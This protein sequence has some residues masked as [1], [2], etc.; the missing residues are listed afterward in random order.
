MMGGMS[1]SH[2]PA[3][4]AALG[5]G[6]ARGLAHVGALKVLEAHGLMPQAVAGT[7]YGA[8]IAALYA[9]GTPAAA[10]ETLVRQQNTL[11]LW[12]QALDLGWLQGS[13][14]HGRRL[15]RWLDRKFFLGA[16][17]SDTELPLAIA[18]TDL[19][20]GRV[21][22]L[23]E[24][25]IARAVVASCALPGLFAPVR[26]GGR[27]LIDG[28]LVEAVPF[29]AL[30][31]LGAYRAI[32]VHA[33]IDADS[34][35][36]VAALRLFATSRAGRA[37]ERVAGSLS[38]RGRFGALMRGMAQLLASYLRPQV[39]PDGALLVTVDPPIAWWDFHRSPEA[40]AAGE[41]AMERALARLER[42][43]VAQ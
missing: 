25:S 33:G 27:V 38:P 15:E 8:V 43:T 36:L 14:I 17:F 11:E 28:G 41:E 10:L 42:T 20:N 35:R 39:V 2:R 4:G 30:K 31:E 26:E 40:I 32:G 34:S 19:E 37:W 9:L 12:A 24:G 7:S 29:G 21:V 1:G 22:V 6:T 13:L 5:G 16:T 18:C 3:I 23:R